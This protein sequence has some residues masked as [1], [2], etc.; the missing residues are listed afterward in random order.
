[1]MGKKDVLTKEYMSKRHYFADAFNSSVFG[2]KQIVKA[3]E[4]NLQEV[5]TEELGI[6]F[7]NKRCRVKN[8]YPDF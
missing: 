2:G 8:F 5:N 3:D 6:V 7:G 4:L 1:M